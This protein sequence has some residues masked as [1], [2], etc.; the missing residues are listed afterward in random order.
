MLT[1]LLY[2][3]QSILLEFHTGSVRWNQEGT[4]AL[5]P[6]YPIS[7]GFSGQH[8]I[9][10]STRP[11]D[12]SLVIGSNQSCREPPLTYSSSTQ[13]SNLQTHS[14]TGTHSFLKL[15]TASLYIGSLPTF[16]IWDS[17]PSHYI[18]G[19]LTSQK[20]C[21]TIFLF[22]HNLLGTYATIWSLQTQILYL[23]SHRVSHPITP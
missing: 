23:E 3:F 20:R 22:Y 17:S 8:F 16:L 4:P 1:T 12:W 18:M 13:S 6:W 14:L 11:L 5:P 2:N 7:T 19:Q 15:L 21:S 10:W 9:P